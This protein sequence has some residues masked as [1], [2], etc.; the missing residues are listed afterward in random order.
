M[1][2][3]KNLREE[4]GLSIIGLSHELRVNP[5]TISMSE[6]RRLAP[7]KNFRAAISGYFKVPDKKLF[8]A[9]GLAI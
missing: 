7:S 3:I 2:N 5:S 9:D 4:H 6:R 1:S 8:G